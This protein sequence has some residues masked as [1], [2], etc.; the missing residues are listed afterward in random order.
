MVSGCENCDSLDIISVAKP[1]AF[2]I[3]CTR[4]HWVDLYQRLHLTIAEATIA[5]IH[6][7]TPSL[8]VVISRTLNNGSYSGFCLPTVPFS[9]YEDHRCCSA[10]RTHCVRSVAQV[11]SV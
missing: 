7:L 8:H 9:F 1:G 4:C 11:Q 3:A 10:F 2:S 5:L 6:C